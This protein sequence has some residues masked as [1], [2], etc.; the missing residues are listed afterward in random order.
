ME[1]RFANDGVPLVQ[2]PKCVLGTVKVLTYCCRKNWLAGPLKSEVLGSGFSQKSHLINGICPRLRP[3]LLARWPK[4]ACLGRDAF[5]IKWLTSGVRVSV[6]RPPSGDREKLV[7]LATL[8]PGV[9]MV[10]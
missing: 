3:S 1:L 6:K 10:D 7:L 5:D 4:T 9:E 8:K 2:K